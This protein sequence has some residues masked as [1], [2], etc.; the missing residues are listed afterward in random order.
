MTHDLW[1]QYKVPQTLEREVEPEPWIEWSCLSTVVMRDV[2]TK[3]LKTARSSPG[4]SLAS[5]SDQG[6][7]VS[8]DAK[9]NDHNLG[10]FKHQTFILSQ[11]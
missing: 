6:M 1:R 10:D 3:G 5:S 8:W 11:F 7:L 2:T 4:L 9:T